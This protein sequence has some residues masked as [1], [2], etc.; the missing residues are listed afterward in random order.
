MRHHLTVLLCLLGG[1]AVAADCAAWSASMQEDEGGPRMT[2]SICAVAS[3]STPEAQHYFLVQCAGSDT[4]AMRY[5]P[6]TD[7]GYPP[8]GDEE[9]ATDLR[10]QLAPETYTLPAR[11]ESMDGAMAFES[12]VNTPFADSLMRAEQIVLSDA[13]GKVPAATFTLKGSRGALQAVIESCAP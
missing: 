12:Q 6:F 7:G 10:L 2:A 13:E 8:G 11:F 3:A 4:L 9:F 5:L 1:P